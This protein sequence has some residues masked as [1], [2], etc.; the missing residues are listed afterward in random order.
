MYKFTWVLN[1]HKIRATILSLL[2]RIHTTG[3]FYQRVL[4]YKYFVFLDFGVCMVEH[5]SFLLCYTVLINA[6]VITENGYTNP[7]LRAFIGLMKTL[8]SKVANVLKNM[9]HSD[10]GALQKVRSH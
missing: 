5:L 3:H 9:L 10:L 2:I 7:E 1:V 4:T 6:S 8:K